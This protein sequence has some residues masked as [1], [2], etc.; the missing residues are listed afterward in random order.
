ME[1]IHQVIGN[2][3]R[4]YNLQESCVDES[5]PWM[6][7]LA[8]EAFSMHYMYHNTKG[9]STGQIAFVR[10]MIIPINQ[11]AYWRY[12]CQNKQEQ[13]DKDVICKNSTRIDHD[14]RVEDQVT[15]RIK[16]VYKYKTPFKGTYEI[17][18]TWTNRTV[19]LKTGVVTTRINI[20]NIR[21]YNTTAL[22]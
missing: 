18:H 6:G 11:V 12:I 20:R 17:F 3:V 21:P 13:I 16:S 9:K 7:I 1:I 15:T 10:D 14:Y 22:A 8:T 5:E 2:L 4:S 19:A